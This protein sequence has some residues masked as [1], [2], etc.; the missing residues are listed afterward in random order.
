MGCK[1]GTSPTGGRRH[2]WHPRASAHHAQP[3]RASRRAAGCYVAVGLGWAKRAKPA[4]SRLPRSPSCSPS[5]YGRPGLKRVLATACGRGPRPAPGPTTGRVRRGVSPLCWGVSSQRAAT[6][7]SAWRPGAGRAPWTL[8][9]RRTR[10]GALLSARPANACPPGCAAPARPHPRAPPPPPPLAP[11]RVAA[12]PSQG[13]LFRRAW[14]RRG[15]PPARWWSRRRA[16]APRRGGR[17]RCSRRRPGAASACTRGRPRRARCP[18]PGVGRQS[19]HCRRHYHRPPPPPPPPQAR[20]QVDAWPP[21]RAHPW[22]RCP[23]ARWRL[24]A[25][26]HARAPGDSN[27]PGRP[28]SS[29][30]AFLRGG[31]G[32]CV[33]ERVWCWVS[34]PPSP[35]SSSSSSSSSISPFLPAFMGVALVAAGVF[36]RVPE[37]GGV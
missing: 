3:V 37:F 18:S 8:P 33:W 31:P 11:H 22:R 7:R 6:R 15:S 27:P 25:P 36:G 12:A 13:V 5:A 10:Q 26:P 32:G 1:S 20:F 35:S 23:C 29:R 24:P 4:S 28:G 21:G 14:T 2:P 9:S 16:A 19:A 17:R 34:S 30:A